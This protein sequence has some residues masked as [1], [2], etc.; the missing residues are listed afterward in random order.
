MERIL[1]TTD[2]ESHSD[3]ALQRAMMLSAEFDAELLVLHVSGKRG[4]AIK[5]LT[6]ELEAQ[7]A[8]MQLPGGTGAGAKY[9]VEVL[10]GDPIAEIVATVSS[11][12]PDLVVM[13]PSSELTMTTIFHGTS[14]EQ[15]IAKITSPVLVVKQRPRSPYSNALVAFDHTP[16]SRRALELAAGLAPQAKFSIVRVADADHGLDNLHDMVAGHVEM[17]GRKLPGTPLAPGKLEILIRTGSIGEDI[18]Q[19]CAV[20]EPDLIAFGRTQKTGLKSFLPGTTASFLLG[21]ARCDAL[22]AA[23]AGAHVTSETRK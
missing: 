8:T 17:I 4:S 23:G 6:G 13:G 19:C 21:H 5:T 22:I 18:L 1:Y 11:F 14:V 12:K 10:S 15:A 9:S 2:L 7:I 20:I 16:G 3:R